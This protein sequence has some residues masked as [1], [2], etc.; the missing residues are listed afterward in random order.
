MSIC[1]L[2]TPASKKYPGIAET[3]FITSLFWVG[4]SK[5]LKRGAR[6]KG[7][8]RA[9]YS[10]KI[11]FVRVRHIFYIAFVR[12]LELFSFLHTEDKG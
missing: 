4:Y 5:I 6:V 11:K 12:S 3:I 7:T 9:D 10:K 2:A 1:I 8:Q